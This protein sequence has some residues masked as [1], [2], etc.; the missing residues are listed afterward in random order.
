MDIRSMYQHIPVFVDIMYVGTGQPSFSLCLDTLE[1]IKENKLHESEIVCD[2][3][4]YLFTHAPG[5]IT[6]KWETLEQIALGALDVGNKDIA[7]LC[8]SRLQNKFPKS[9]RV[10]ILDAM[11][12]EAF[13]E[14]TEAV[15]L[16]DAIFEEDCMAIN[17]WK[18]KVALASKRGQN[19]ALEELG[20][21][22]NHYQTD[23]ESWEELSSLTENAKKYGEAAFAVEEVILQQ[24][25]N[26]FAH[27]KC[28]QLH[29]KNRAGLNSLLAARG[30]YTIGLTCIDEEKNIDFKETCLNGILSCCRAIEELG[31]KAINAEQKTLNEAMKK[32]A[33]EKLGLASEEV[34]EES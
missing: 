31:H 4:N 6:S 11:M 19:A 13:G 18:R 29:F 5:K 2:I 24:P 10:A 12:L 1:E 28:A 26:V 17:A 32:S 3:G 23:V 15:K 14:G 16:Y 7:D 21:L 20:K 9:N 25:R 34:S 27:I 33:M 30:H 8:V 22:L